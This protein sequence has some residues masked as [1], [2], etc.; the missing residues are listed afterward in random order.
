VLGKQ[1]DLPHFPVPRHK[2]LIEDPAEPFEIT[3][4]AQRL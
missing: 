1:L 4:A 2:A 3:L